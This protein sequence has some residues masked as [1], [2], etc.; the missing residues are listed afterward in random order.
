MPAAIKAHQGWWA[1]RA[2]AT[3]TSETMSQTKRARSSTTCRRPPPQTGCA[4]NSSRAASCTV[5]RLKGD[6]HRCGKGLR[7]PRLKAICLGR[8]P[9]LAAE[10]AALVSA[11]NGPA[12]RRAQRQAESEVVLHL[13][14]RIHPPSLHLP[15]AEVRFMDLLPSFASEPS[16]ATET[17]QPKAELRA[18]GVSGR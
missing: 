9:L 14:E 16:F 10:G 2:M 7:L 5:W 3:R 1:S 6:D 12:R 4:T 11:R 18:G 17:S 15:Q 13:G 8:Q